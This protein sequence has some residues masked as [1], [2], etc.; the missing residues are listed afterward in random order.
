MQNLIVTSIIIFSIGILYRYGAPT[1]FKYR[2][3]YCLFSLFTRLNAQRLAKKMNPDRFKND[4]SSCCGC[5]K[6][7][8]QTENVHPIRIVRKTE[9]DK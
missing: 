1:A 9:T 6:C 2:V 5:S 4:Q 7:P 8:P 3:R